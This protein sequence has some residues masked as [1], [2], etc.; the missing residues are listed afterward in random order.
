MIIRI[1]TCAVVLILM[2]IPLGA[3]ELGVIPYRLESSGMP[4]SQEITGEYP[5][6]IGLASTVGR[7]LEL[8]KHY[9]LKRDMRSLGITAADALTEDECALLAKRRMLSHI[10]SGTVYRVDDGY[11]AR[12]F[13]F[14]A[15]QNTIVARSNVKGRTLAELAEADAVQLFRFDMKQA[16]SKQKTYDSAVLLDTSFN[17]SEEFAAVREGLL[18]HYGNLFADWPRSRLYIQA[19]NSLQT[20]ESPKELSSRASLRDFLG[21]VSL[22]G[23]NTDDSIR[24]SLRSLVSNIPWRNRT[25]KYALLITNSPVRDTTSFIRYVNAASS[26]NITVHVLLGARVDSGSR[27]GYVNIAE[28]TGGRVM[29]LTYHRVFRD[30]QNREQHFYYRAGRIYTSAEEYVQW[31]TNRPLASLQQQFP[32][33]SRITPYSFDDVYRKQMDGVIVSSSSLESNAAFLLNDLYAGYSRQESGSVGRVLFEELGTTIWSDVA[34]ARMLE[35]F[36]K[37]KQAGMT[38]IIGVRL[39]PDG[40]SPYGYSFHSRMYESAYGI[41]DV[42]RDL[43]VPLK[44]LLS[45]P[46]QYAGSGFLKP[47]LY[48]INVKISEVRSQTEKRDIRTN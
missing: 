17:M 23:G 34:D 12:S 10:I 15:S 28:P 3:D 36:Q 24:N 9:Q 13:L 41:D 6:Y 31:R 32:G 18:S 5:K 19:F 33:Q 7:K 45:A 42:P 29:D 37:M 43:V 48:F 8:Y 44:K 22:R 14:S 20:A 38:F 25:Q 16:A 11:L 47:P 40:R 27:A 35:S 30:H 26:R 21:S 39:V 2:C 46:E 1:Y 4:V